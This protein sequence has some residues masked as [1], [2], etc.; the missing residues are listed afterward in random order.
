M[1][2]VLSACWRRKG[3]TTVGLGLIA[4]A[5]VVGLKFLRS[6]DDQS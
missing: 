6:D 3:R 2:R 5:T 4:L 1:G